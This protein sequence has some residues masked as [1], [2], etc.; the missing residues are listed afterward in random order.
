MCYS[1]AALD[2]GNLNLPGIEA[3]MFGPGDLSLAHTDCDL[4]AMEEVRAAAK[5]RAA[6]V[7]R[8]FA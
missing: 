6:A 4:V 3:V 8:L 2:A 7:L 5:I 1:P